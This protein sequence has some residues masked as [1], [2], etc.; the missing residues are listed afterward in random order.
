MWNWTTED[1][2]QYLKTIGNHNI[3]KGLR[4]TARKIE[5]LKNYLEAAKYRVH[6]GQ[7]DRAQVL[8]AARRHLAD[9]EGQ[10]A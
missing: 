10:I 5:Y 1:E 9:L 7:I 3:V 4:T 8:A 2:L 6:W